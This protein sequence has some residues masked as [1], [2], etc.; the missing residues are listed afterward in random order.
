MVRIS[1]KSYVKKAAKKV[2]KAICTYTGSRY[3]RTRSEIATKGVTQL[4]K[5]V[6]MIKK[7]INVEKK[8]HELS[9]SQYVGQCNINLT[10]VGIQE[11]TPNPAQGQ[12]FTTRNGRSIKLTGATLNMQFIEMSS[13]TT[14][15]NI[16]VMVIQVIGNPFTSASTMLTELYDA[17]PL[18]SIIDYNSDRNPVNFK[19]FRILCNKRVTMP[20]ENYNAQNGRQV[21]KKIN[22]KL[23]SHIKYDGNSTTIVDGQIYMIAIPESGNANT[24]TA[25]TLSYVALQAANTGFVWNCYTRF[26]F[27]DN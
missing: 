7:L 14:R 5:D 6:M 1:K 13:Q 2:G 26:Y 10:G 8:I 4:A 19:Q 25:S 21:T 17:N 15:V 12:T 18:T 11:I 16:R 24:A 20:T 22:L 3:G 9:F 27:V 23:T